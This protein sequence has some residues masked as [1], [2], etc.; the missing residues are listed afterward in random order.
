MAEKSSEIPPEFEEIRARVKFGPASAI[1]VALLKESAEFPFLAGW[2]LARLLAW[3]LFDQH[4]S[5][6]VP[7]EEREDRAACRPFRPRYAYKAGQLYLW[8][9]L[10]YFYRTYETSPYFRRMTTDEAVVALA[11]YFE[12][13]HVK[14]EIT[15]RGK[16]LSSLHNDKSTRR[17]LLFVYH[18][19]DFL[20][21]ATLSGREDLCKVERARHFAEKSEPMDEHLSASGVEKAW[22]RYRD[23]APYI[24]AFYPKLYFVDSQAGSFAETKKISEEDWISRIALLAERSTLEECLGHAAFAADVLVKTT[25]RVVRDNDFETVARKEPVWRDFD[26]AELFLI[27][28]FTKTAPIK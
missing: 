20:V 8:Y 19:M 18:V 4:E 15:H 10:D 11:W 21:R 6:R 16:T 5:Q 14:K 28:T 13:A 12:T 22:N 1:R 27:N 2:A 25:T 23:A 3:A 9:Y 26:A 7:E 17:D 24:Y